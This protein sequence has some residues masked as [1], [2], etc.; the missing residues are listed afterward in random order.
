MYVSVNV[1]D[2]FIMCRESGFGSIGD[3]SRV[4]LRGGF[5]LIWSIYKYK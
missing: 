2:M 4:E 1:V 5:T 3:M